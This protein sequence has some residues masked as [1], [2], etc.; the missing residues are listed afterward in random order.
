M[1]DSSSRVTSPGRTG[2][3]S[4]T[5]QHGCSQIGD[6]ETQTAAALEQIACNPNVGGVRSSSASAARP[7]R[8]GGARRARSAGGGQRTEF[9]GIQDAGAARPPPSR[10]GTQVAAHARWADTPGSGRTGDASELVLGIEAAR[11]SARGRRPGTPR[12]RRRGPRGLRR[13]RRGAGGRWSRGWRGRPSRRWGTRFPRAGGRPRCGAL[14]AAPSSTRGAGR[15]RR[16]GHARLLPRRATK[17]PSASPL[18]PVVAVSGP[19]P[20]HQALAGEFDLGTRPPAPTRSG[21]SCSRGSTQ[22]PRPRPSRAGTRRV[23]AQPRIAR[24]M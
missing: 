3:V 11:R 22:G 6:D 19:S 14:G 16:A 10:G 23:R 5:H 13:H 12:H 8:A 15:R 24:T 17:R 4:I 2:A 7:S 9:V 1:R 18:C 21:G 20:L